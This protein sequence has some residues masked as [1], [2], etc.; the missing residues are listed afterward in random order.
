MEFRMN[1]LLIVFVLGFGIANAQI[2]SELSSFLV[3]ERFQLHNGLVHYKVWGLFDLIIQNSREFKL[4]DSE[5]ESLTNAKYNFF[6]VEYLLREEE[7]WITKSYRSIP[8]QNENN[9]HLKLDKNILQ[10]FKKLHSTRWYSSGMLD[11]VINEQDF[12]KIKWEDVN[13]IVLRE[14]WVYNRMKGGIESFITSIGF[15]INLDGNRKY[16]AWANFNIFTGDFSTVF[17]KHKL[18][19]I[20][21]NKQL[22]S[23]VFYTYMDDMDGQINL[24][25]R[26]YTVHSLFIEIQKINE[27]LSLPKVVDKKGN[28]LF[29]DKNL[30]TK[31]KGNCW[32]GK[33]ELMDNQNNLLLELN[34]KNKVLNGAYNFF[35]NNGTLREKG[36]FVNGL[37][38]GEC[39]HYYSTSK[40]AAKRVYGNGV[41][42]GEQREF[43]SN[44]S[45]AVVYNY[46]N[47]FLN[48]SF[49]Q[50]YKDGTLMQSGFFVNGLVNGNWTYN[51]IIPKALREVISRNT[52]LFNR[53]FILEKKWTADKFSGKTFNFKAY[54]EQIQSPECIQGICT[55]VEIL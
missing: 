39:V 43:Y 36:V 25:G 3:S 55:Q 32:E 46:Q 52:E 50:Y 20:L 23:D 14:D 48:G 49:N 44:G 34:F 12:K 16:L 53:K 15:A 35:Y 41:M 45:P 19:T 33:L 51:L 24:Q 21:K 29:I 13:E 47:G 5:L 22:Y 31:I 38:N 8:I 27:Y 28:V 2:K 7:H 4:Q 37:K 11:Q 17:P 42:D 54:I 10:E 40:I 1:K 6:P 30:N 18:I 26:D 9:S